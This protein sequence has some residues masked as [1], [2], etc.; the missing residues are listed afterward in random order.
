MNSKLTDIE[1]GIKVEGQALI[2]QLEKRVKD[3]NDWL[4]DYGIDCYMTFYLK[5]DDPHYDEDSDNILVE[6]STCVIPHIPES[7]SYLF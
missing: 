2:A 5:E 4:E 6:L 7:N 1:K 3:T